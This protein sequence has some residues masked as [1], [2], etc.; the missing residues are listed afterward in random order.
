MSGA[1]RILVVDDVRE[2]VRLLEAVLDAHGYET[3]AAADG[4]TALELALSAKPDLVLLDVLM[5]QPDGYAVCRRL[6]E[7]EE[8]AVL[9]VIMLTASE[10]SEKTKAIEAGA[11]DFIPKPFNREELLTRIRSLL[12]IKR[13]HDTI[14]SQAA[15]LL[16]LN[17]TLEERVRSQLEQLERLQRLRRFLSPQLADAIVSSGDESILRSHRR[18]VAMIFVD[19]RGWTGF[20]DTVEPEELM[21][22]LREF[23][24]TIGGLV[25]RFDATV[26]FIEGDG[27]QLFFNDPIEVPDAALR[28][29]RLGC[30]LRHEMAELTA[31]WQKRGYELDFGA[32]MALG[33][34]TCGE[35]GFEE[36]SDYAAVG[37]V[38]NLASR[39]ADEAAAGQILITQRLYA[40]V[41]DDVD[42]QSMGEFRLKGFQR[43]VAAFDVLGVRDHAS[44]T[45]PLQTS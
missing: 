10:G 28:A 27:V 23:H 34:A 42:V 43:P 4:H 6:R 1:A 5:P 7:Q 14:T 45:R 37:A 18:Q 41:G 40:E 38:T 39:L 29:I 9:P 22:V 32:G 8:T 30:T 3:V 36:R 21:R 26:G 33:Y 16:D 2:N 15:E 24:G 44:E 19:L 17:R 12:R 20:V 13:Y 35:V 11:D 31:R 25:R